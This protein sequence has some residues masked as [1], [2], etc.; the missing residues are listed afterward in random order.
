MHWFKGY[1]PLKKEQER[2][3]REKSK[4]ART[5]IIQEAMGAADKLGPH[6]VTTPHPQEILP[7]PPRLSQ[8]SK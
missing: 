2:D 6:F 8:N 7:L 4:A 5:S 3:G 1:I